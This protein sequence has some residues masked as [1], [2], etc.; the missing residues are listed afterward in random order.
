ML[1]FRDIGSLGL[2]CRGFRAFRVCCSENLK[3]LALLAGFGHVKGYE[4]SVVG[5]CRCLNMFKLF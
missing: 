2:R 5:K 1:G 4:E 3:T